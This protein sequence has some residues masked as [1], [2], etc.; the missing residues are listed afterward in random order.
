[1][2]RLIRGR[3]RGSRLAIA[4]IVCVLFY[5]EFFIYHLNSKKWQQLKCTDEDSC[6]KIV[7]VADPQ[8]IGKLNEVIHFLT[9]FSIWDSDRYLRVTYQSVFNFIKPDIVIFLGDLFDEGSISVQHDFSNY[10]DRLYTIFDIGKSSG[11]QYIWLPG[12]NDIGGEGTDIVT[13]EKMAKF[14][15]AFPQSDREQYANISFY[16]INKLVQYVPLIE[17]NNDF[18]NPNIVR[19]ALSHVPIFKGY[20][21]FT[22]QVVHQLEPHVLF[23]AHEHKSKVIRTDPNNLYDRHVEV[24]DPRNPKKFQYDLN[25]ESVYEFMVPTC[26]YRMGTMN[27]GYGYAIIEGKNIQYTVLWSPVRFPTLIVYGFILILVTLWL[28]T[29][30]CVILCKKVLK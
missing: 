4:I 15:R 30:A 14:T 11:I 17:D 18:S 27:M 26:S 2:R 9:P 25:S 29:K 16:K 20:S 24:T 22:K 6:V 5:T 3:L 1:M 10:V 8:I 13:S 7:L 19:V 23:T 12:D 21:S 28:L